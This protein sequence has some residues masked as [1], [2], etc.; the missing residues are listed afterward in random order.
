MLITGAS[1]FIGSFLVEEGRKRGYRVFATVQSSNERTIMEKLHLDLYPFDFTR[2]AEV[3]ENLIKYREHGIEFDYVIHA[4]AVNRPKRIEEFYTG[5]GDFTPF[6]ANELKE[7]HSR[8]KKFIF[9]SS[10]AALGPG[11]E[12]TFEPITEAREPNPTTPYGVSKRQAEIKLQQIQD[13]NYVIFR[14]TAVY[15]PRDTKLLV[16]I[17]NMMEKG[18]EVRVGSPRQKSSFLYVKDLVGFIFRSIEKDQ[19][20]REIFNV[21]DGEVYTQTELNRL[22]KDALDVNP[23]PLR[24]PTWMM[25]GISYSMLLGNQIVRKPLHLSPYKVR[26]ITAL[27]WIIDISK[28]K[29]MLGYTPRY[30]LEAG[31]REAVDWYRNGRA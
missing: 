1:G 26:E 20:S 31:V 12:E 25:M 22:I 29:Q 18:I 9:I 17:M 13:L 21:S 4:A 6:F 19:V 24:I 28:A 27:N 23:I 11:N 16:R 14:P 2:P 15:G 10:M 7:K 3:S 8:F 30:S 5:N